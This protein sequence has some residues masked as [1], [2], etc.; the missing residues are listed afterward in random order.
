MK[1]RWLLALLAANLLVLVTLVFIYPQF[2]VAPGPLLGGH[3]HLETDCFAC[4]ARIQRQRGSISANR[5]VIFPIRRRIGR[6]SFLYAK[7][8]TNAS[9]TVQPVR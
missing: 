3:T 8:N 1:R 9:V 6:L 2:M 5:A 4:H 7:L